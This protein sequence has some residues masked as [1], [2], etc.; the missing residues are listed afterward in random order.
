VVENGKG[1]ASGREAETGGVGLE[2]KE[3]RRKIAERLVE[4]L[5][6]AHY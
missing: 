1:G 2:G 6:K 4:N 3:G 5:L